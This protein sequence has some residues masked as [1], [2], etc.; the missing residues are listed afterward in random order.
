MTTVSPFRHLVETDNMPSLLLL[1]AAIVL[2]Y[3][4]IAVY[5]LYFSPLAKFPGPKIAGMSHRRV[6]LVRQEY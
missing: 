1:A 4:C 6:Q 5:R 2:Y 3:A